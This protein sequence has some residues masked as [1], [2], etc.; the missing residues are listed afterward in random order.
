LGELLRSAQEVQSQEKKIVLIALGHI[1]QFDPKR[2]SATAGSI[3][4]SYGRTFSWSAADLR[5][6]N[7]SAEP[8]QKFTDN[9][10]DDERYVLYRL[11]ANPCRQ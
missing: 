11:A 6:W 8:V 10:I 3:E 9:V 4:Y 2:I 7:E 1:D 5:A